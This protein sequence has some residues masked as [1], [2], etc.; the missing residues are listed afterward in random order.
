MR[1]IATK[2]FIFC[3]P[4]VSIFFYVE[5]KLRQVP[6]SYTIKKR[7]LEKNSKKIETVV[8]GSSQA[9]YSV[10]PLYFSS[11]TIN[12]ANASQS[13]YFDVALLE[14][15]ADKLP[16]LKKVI[17]PV[18]YFSLFYDMNDGKEKMRAYAYY[19]YYNLKN[20]DFNYCDIKNYSLVSLL[21]IKRVLV[22]AKSGFKQ[23]NDENI[24]KMTTEGFLPYDSTN[25]NKRINDS[26]GKEW[27][28][29]HQ[30]FMK[31]S[32]F[33]FNINCLNR[34]LQ[35]LTKKNIQVYFISTPTYKTY[36]QNF[37]TLIVRTNDS[38]INSLCRSYNCKYFNWSTD[39]SFTKQDFYDNDHLNK[40]GAVKFSKLLD[41][42]I[43][44]SN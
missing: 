37:D 33:N 20:H 40:Y 29:Y 18:S 17:I 19:H 44:Q 2:I 6:N 27:L 7:Y 3:L 21:G 1:K 26:L 28:A 36:Y 39:T 4:L 9:L 8:L 16:S 10:N 11:K 14:K 5:Y 30:S 43:T 24:L 23:L 12:L 15:Y 35:N 38:V 13:L 42:T 25:L 31:K 22:S 34:L 41:S 32:S